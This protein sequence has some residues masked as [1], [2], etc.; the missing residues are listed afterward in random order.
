ML[1]FFDPSQ[2]QNFEL[3]KAQ[4][5]KWV[6]YFNNNT[7]VYESKLSYFQTLVKDFEANLFVF[8]YRTTGKLE[9]L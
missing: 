7:E 4:N 3:S 8:N 9:E 1:L 5:Q 6:V 2:K